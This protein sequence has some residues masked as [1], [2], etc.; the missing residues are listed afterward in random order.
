MRET[1]HSHTNRVWKL[2]GA[3]DFVAM[4]GETLEA[5][6]IGKSSETDDGFPELSTVCAR[7]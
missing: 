1:S 3:S 7:Y 6:A 4:L 2:L 5:L